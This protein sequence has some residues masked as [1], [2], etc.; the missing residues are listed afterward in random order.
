VSSGP[1]TAD[2]SEG[3][4]APAAVDGLGEARRRRIARRHL[5]WLLPLAVIVLAGLVSLLM[6]Q[7]APRPETAE[8]PAPLP[9]VRVATVQPETLRMHVVAHGSVAPRTE[10]DLVAEVRGRIVKVAPALVAGGF[11]SSGDQLLQ[12]DDREHRIAVD[13]ARAQVKLRGSEARLAAAEAARRQQLADRGAASA[14]DLEQYESRALVAEAALDEARAA[15]QQTKLDLER[16]VVRA[17]FDGRVRERPVDVGQFVN[18]GTKLARIYA[19]DYAEVRLPIATEDLVHLD[20]ALAVRGAA[21]DAIEGAP[22][23]LRARLGGRDLEWAATLVRT[24]GEIDLRTRTLHLVARVDDPYGRETE[25]LSPLPSGLFVEA[26][27]EGRELEGVFVLPSGAVR[28]EDRVYLV[29]AE[30][31]LVVRPVEVVR[32]DRERAVIGSGLED[33]D[34]VVVSPLRAVSEGMRLRTVEEDAS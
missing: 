10:S 2:P 11:F 12:L 14:A 16:T 21:H 5:R 32:R 19:V 27:I 3:T 30:D 26:E 29:D 9:L 1:V 23:T 4:P 31:R 25:R 22:I 13:R 20:L 24:E 7:S 17:P 8:P 33:G 6:F 18:P 28:D 34:R 15:L